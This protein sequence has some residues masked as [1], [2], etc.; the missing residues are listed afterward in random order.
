MKLHKYMLGFKYMHSKEKV[1]HSREKRK[2]RKN[3]KKK[4][5]RSEKRWMKRGE[6]EMIRSSPI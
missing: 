2:Q 4:N 1:M 3:M 6:E 5:T